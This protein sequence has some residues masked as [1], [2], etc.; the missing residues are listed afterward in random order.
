M[1]VIAPLAANPAAKQFVWD[2]FKTNYK[3][4][5]A[6]FYAGSFLLGRLI[7]NVCGGFATDEAAAEV[8]KFFD[9]CGLERDAV[10]RAI[11]QS[12]ES[13][14]ANAR[15]LQ[16]CRESVTAFLERGEKEKLWE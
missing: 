16:S 11:E 10:K 15:W 14:K 9:D 12:V 7:S 6:R 8:T 4:I 5:H 2:W 1:S 13:V 3:T